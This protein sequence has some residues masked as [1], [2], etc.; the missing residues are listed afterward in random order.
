[1]LTYKYTLNFTDVN[2]MSFTTISLYL[3]ILMVCAL[4]V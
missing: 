2:K 4:L 3:Q 1:M